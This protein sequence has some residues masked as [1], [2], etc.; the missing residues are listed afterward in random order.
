LSCGA[1]ASDLGTSLAGVAPARFHPRGYPTTSEPAKRISAPFLSRGEAFPTGYPNGRLVE[2]PQKIRQQRRRG[3][4]AGRHY[5][6]HRN[7]IVLLHSAG[8]AYRAE[9]IS[10]RGFGDG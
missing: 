10:V 4:K 3:E 9:P 2:V 6:R 5:E 7:P 1:A 8:G